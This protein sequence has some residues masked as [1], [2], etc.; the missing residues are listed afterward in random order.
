MKQ[1]LHTQTGTMGTRGVLDTIDHLVFRCDK[2]DRRPIVE[3]KREV[4][5]VS[6]F[7]G[8]K[9]G[10]HSNDWLSKSVRLQTGASQ[11]SEVV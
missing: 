7:R 3:R 1:R 2:D 4:S 6:E 5:E 11:S 8:V 9:Q 10:S